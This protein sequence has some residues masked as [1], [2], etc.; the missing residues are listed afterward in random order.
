MPRTTPR[1]PG[2]RRDAVQLEHPR[3]PGEPIVDEV[4]IPDPDLRRLGR[5]SQPARDLAVAL[6]AAV[7]PKDLD[8]GVARDSL[9]V[10]AW[11]SRAHVVGAE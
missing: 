9:N 3:V 6:P 2:R 11:S 1:R 4:Q 7:S 5:Q 8:R 10:E